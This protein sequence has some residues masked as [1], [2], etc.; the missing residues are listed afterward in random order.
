MALNKKKVTS[1]KDLSKFIDANLILFGTDTI[2]DF[3]NF[4]DALVFEGLKGNDFWR[5]S[6]VFMISVVVFDTLC[7]ERLDASHGSTEVDK[8]LTVML[9]AGVI[10]EFG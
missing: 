10:D 4:G 2:K 8:R 7:T 9:N 3:S 6:E 5:S 1:L